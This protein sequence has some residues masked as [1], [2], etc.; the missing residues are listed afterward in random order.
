MST[1][2]CIKIDGT[3]HQLSQEVT[4]MTQNISIDLV[5]MKEEIKDN[6]TDHITVMKGVFKDGLYKSSS[7]IHDQMKTQIA[8]WNYR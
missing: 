3:V 6:V 2:L 8:N 1:W 4:N 5:D 7:L